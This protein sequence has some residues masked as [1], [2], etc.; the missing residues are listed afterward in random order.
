MEEQIVKR[1][2]SDHVA[3][4]ELASQQ[5][6][7]DRLEKVV[8]KVAENTITMNK[9]V[10]V[11]EEKIIKF[12]EQHKSLVQDVKAVSSKVDESDKQINKSVAEFGSKFAEA[13]KDK[14]ED[15]VDK[16][17]ELE[18]RISKIEQWKW[19]IVGIAGAIGY[20]IEHFNVFASK[21]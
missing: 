9:M 15:T 21:P 5:R 3:D 4:I 1:R 13:H 20:Y 12:E 16:I 11:H 10:A 2:A 14:L 6:T 19:F 17:E 18:E 7:I 8:E